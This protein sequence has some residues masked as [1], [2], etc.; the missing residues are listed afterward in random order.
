MACKVDFSERSFAYKLVE[1]VVSDVLELRRAEFTRYAGELEATQ[2]IEGLLHTR[3][4][5]CMSVRA[6]RL[7]VLVCLRRKEGEVKRGLYLISMTLELRRGFAS[8]KHVLSR[9]SIC[10]AMYLL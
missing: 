5:L 2:R 4:E 8:R 10:D 6:G 1:L 3:R 9:L 7:L